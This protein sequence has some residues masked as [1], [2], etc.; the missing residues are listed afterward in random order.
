MPSLQIEILTYAPTEFF[1]CLHCEVVFQSVGLGQPVRRE[2]RAAAFPPD[3]QAEY[4]ALADWVGGVVAR[5]GDRVRVRVVDAASLEGV[6]K[7]LRYRSRRFP[8]FVI[9]GLVWRQGA[10]YAALDQEID[11]R[12]RRAGQERDAQ[13]A[14]LD[15]QQLGR[16]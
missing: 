16:G 7:S 1:H 8:V 9:D 2:Q 15:T 5:H 10:N 6:Y 4:A 12:L 3:L 14:A 13:H 11:A